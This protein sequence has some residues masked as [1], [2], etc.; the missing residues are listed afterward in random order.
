MALCVVSLSCLQG[1]IYNWGVQQLRYHNY[2][3][4]GEGI[5]CKGFPYVS[6]KVQLVGL[7]MEEV[8]RQPI[9]VVA[10]GL[11]QTVVFAK[12]PHLIAS[13]YRMYSFAPICAGCRIHFT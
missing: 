2:R 5:H 12:C 13:Y 3:V 1:I 10:K 8:G 7:K 9:S 6:G 4:A 11:K